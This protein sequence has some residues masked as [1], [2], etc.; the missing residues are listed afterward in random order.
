MPEVNRPVILALV[1]GLLMGLLALSNA[2]TDWVF[3]IFLGGPWLA[4]RVLGLSQGLFG[5]TTCVY[6]TFLGGLLG[7]AWSRRRRTR[8]L[9]AATAVVLIAHASLTVA[10]D[11]R[12]FREFFGAVRSHGIPPF[13]P[14][15]PPA[16]PP[17]PSP[18]RAP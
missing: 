17:P 12:L 13:D 11:H 8:F 1:A 15:R 10:G 4:N 2:N 14:W 3:L 18:T 6:Y 9:G 7:L 5:V 16:T